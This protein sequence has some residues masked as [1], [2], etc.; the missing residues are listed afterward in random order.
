M[1]SRRGCRRDGNEKAGGEKDHTKSV[2]S[3]A[4]AQ[5]REDPQHWVP[6]PF[7][8]QQLSDNNG[9]GIRGGIIRTE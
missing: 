1:D 7:P 4:K 2:E 3:G 5:G 9:Q 6:A 8:K